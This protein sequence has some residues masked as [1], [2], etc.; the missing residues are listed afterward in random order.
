MA[1]MM[2]LQ[3]LPPLQ[4]TSPAVAK[5]L[6]AFLAPSWLIARLPVNYNWAILCNKAA[7]ISMANNK[8]ALSCSQL[9]CQGGSVPYMFHSSG[10]RG[11]MWQNS[12]QEKQAESV[13]PLCVQAQNRLTAI[14]VHV[15]LAKVSP[16][17]TKARFLVEGTAKLS[18]EGYGYSEGWGMRWSNNVICVT[19][20][21]GQDVNVCPCRWQMCLEQTRVYWRQCLGGEVA[22]G[23]C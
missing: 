5:T 21:R 8:H 23:S 20:V 10:A 19:V 3:I 2:M 15:P 12:A 22:S 7:Q 4:K 6:R 16:R 17:G 18:K 1:A 11:M 9:I 13:L 14:S